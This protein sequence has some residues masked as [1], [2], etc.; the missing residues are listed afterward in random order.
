MKRFYLFLGGL[1]A[2]ILIAAVCSAQT[3]PVFKAGD[4]VRIAWTAPADTDVVHYTCYFIQLSGNYQTT[5]VDILEW[6]EEGGT[7]TNP[8]GFKLALVDGDYELRLT[9][10][11]AAGNES[12]PS[13]PYNFKVTTDLPP[14]QPLNVYMELVQVPTATGITA[15]LSKVPRTVTGVRTN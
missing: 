9:A 14:G 3:V 4:T 10:V 6:N 13:E 5:V 15:K 12:L 2:F 1:A 11:D 8:A 7:S